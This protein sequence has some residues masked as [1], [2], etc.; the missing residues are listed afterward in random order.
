[1]GR[2]V[3]VMMVLKQVMVYTPN[4]G[5]GLPQLFDKD[6]NPNIQNIQ[7]RE[8]NNFFNVPGVKYDFIPTEKE[9]KEFKAGDRVDPNQFLPNNEKEFVDL[10]EGKVRNSAESERREAKRNKDYSVKERYKGGGINPDGFK[11]DPGLKLPDYNNDPHL[12]YIEK[13]K[14]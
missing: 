11:R 14:K 13:D 1:M 10:G 5:S 2:P 4:G 7:P 9:E 12:K 6:G 3:P 8:N